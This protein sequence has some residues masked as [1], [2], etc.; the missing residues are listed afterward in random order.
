MS[1]E[2]WRFCVVGYDANDVRSY[3]GVSDTLDGAEK[4][5]ASAK[6]IGWR[7]VA[8]LDSD[9]R[10]IHFAQAG[11]RRVGRSNP[12]RK[13]IPIDRKSDPRLNRVRTRCFL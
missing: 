10:E 9:L 1:E 4:L 3:L 13:N 12:K 2:S 8:V 5:K 11:F 7:R 6:T